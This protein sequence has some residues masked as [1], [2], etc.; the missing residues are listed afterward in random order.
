MAQITIRE[1]DLTGN[2]A[3]TTFDVAAV[4]GLTINDLDELDEKG[5]KKYLCDY[6]APAFFDSLDDFQAM[7]GDRPVELT[8]AGIAYDY[9]EGVGITTE[10]AEDVEC[11]DLTITTGDFSGTPSPLDFILF[12]KNTDSL[13]NPQIMEL[14]SETFES[15]RTIDIKRA[16]TAQSLVGATVVRGSAGNWVVDSVTGGTPILSKISY[17]DLA[18]TELASIELYANPNCSVTAHEEV[19]PSNIATFAL[20]EVINA[21]AVEENRA[22]AF[23][24]T[25][26][27]MVAA[28]APSADGYFF[29]A[30]AKENRNLDPGYIYACELLY[31]GIPVYYIPVKGTTALAVYEAMEGDTE[32]DVKS[33]FDQLRDRGTY[34]VKYLTS[35]GYPTYEYNDNSIVKLM[36]EVAG[37][38]Q[39]TTD[40]YT[41]F[42]VNTLTIKN[43]RGDCLA[44]IDHFELDIRNLIGA[45]SVYGRVQKDYT[46]DVCGLAGLNYLSYAALFTPYAQYNLQRK[47]VVGDREV[48][49]EYLPAS[50]AY[51]TC[52]A[53]QL[54]GPVPSYEAT[55]GVGRGMVANVVFNRTTNKYNVCTKEVLT[56]YIAN[57]FNAPMEADGKTPI[58]INALTQINPYGIV[59]WGDRTLLQ[60]NKV[61][62]VKATGI[63]SIRNMV[64]DI[65]KQMYQT[66][67]RYMFSANND[68]LWINFRSG[69]VGLLNQMKSGYGIKSYSLR[70]DTE[71]STKNALYVLCSIQPVYPVEKFD[72]TIEITDEDVEVAETVNE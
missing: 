40:D 56:N 43:G 34:N 53:K 41:D 61:L 36:L 65:K 9:T 14:E 25:L 62:G 57:Y 11:A 10:V 32:N 38:D 23:P 44:L 52:L 49:R 28:V 47:Y 72:I 29:G 35:G 58:S 26:S 24:V 30:D 33:I 13:P 27:N 69:V 50:F 12:D 5:N 21:Q 6:N 15:F 17:N 64:S 31:A 18:D 22:L 71:K 60:K 63:V 59:V 48:S 46:Q 42:D 37:A 2:P 67:R 1:K 45:G 54:N 51:M 68:A 20:S 55:A 66:A 39:D 7:F 70:K 16:K 4:P 8:G 19:D 3:A